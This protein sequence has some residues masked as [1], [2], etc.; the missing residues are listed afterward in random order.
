MTQAV[1]I[2]TGGQS[3]RMGQDKSQLQYKG[4][5]LVDWQCSRFSA[6]GFQVVSQLADRFPGFLGPLAGIDAALAQFPHIKHW[7]VV[8]V[9]MPKL[10]TQIVDTLFTQGAQKSAPVAFENA[11]MPIYLNNN[12]ELIQ[13]LESWLNDEQGKRSV[14]ALLTQLKGHWL[15]NTDKAEELENFNTPAE[16][17]AALSN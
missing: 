17:Q 10:S 9:D 4:Q 6:V 11:P 16:W 5:A 15:P 3:R 8:P 7:V 14:Y 12:P 2:L 13:T 1:L